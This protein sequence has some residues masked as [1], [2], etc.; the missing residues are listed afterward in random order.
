MTF[1][2]LPPR[3]RAYILVSAV[4]AALTSTLALCGHRFD[5]WGLFVGLLGLAA[6]A[7][8]LKV[9]LPVQW[10]RMSLGSAVTFFAL[11]QL[12]APEAI[13]VNAISAL[14]SVR[15]AST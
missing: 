13:A 5:D 11:L 15:T 4:L 10:G 6:L 8:A 12:G 7:G 3:L 2:Q 14:T 9:E 1:A